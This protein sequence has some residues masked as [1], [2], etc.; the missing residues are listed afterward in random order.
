M[1]IEFSVGNFRSIKDIQTLSMIAAP[2]TSKNKELDEQNTFQATEKIKLLKTKAIYGANASGKT[3]IIKALIAFR[4]IIINSFKNEKSV[5]E[6]SDV[7]LLGEDKDSEKPIFMQIIFILDGITYRYGYE[8][9]TQG[10]LSEWLYGKPNQQEVYYFI[11][12]K[13][14]IKFNHNKIKNISKLLNL[15]PNLLQSTS[16]ILSMSHIFDSLLLKSINQYIYRLFIIDNL[17]NKSIQLV[18][19]L[20]SYKESLNKISSM[21]KMADTAIEKIETFELKSDNENSWLEKSNIKQYEG[22]GFDILNDI[23]EEKRKFVIMAYHKNLYK[24]NRIQPF[25]FEFQESEGT[26]K[27]LELS[28]YIYSSIE[29]GELLVL[30]EFD[31]RF[32]PL[33]SKKI[34]ELF[35]KNTNHAQFICATHDTN[36]LDAKLLR[37]DQIAFVEKDKFGASHLYDLVEFKGVRN[38][39][40]FEKDYL[41]GRYGAIPFLGDFDSIFAK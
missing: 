38:D 40:S 36:L 15:S 6:N 9:M 18:A 16:L 21:L 39:A 34:V 23:I 8:Y 27:L 37:R 22:D 3:N 12:D 35:N 29:E 41:E 24:E 31:A 17:I 32:H 14:D 13:E 10:V 5:F 20:L 25:N 2:I 33:I 7:F 4:D 19:P 28:P 1:L 30:D 11:R 26:K